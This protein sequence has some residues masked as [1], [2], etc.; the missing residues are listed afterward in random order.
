M[1]PD[2]PVPVRTFR[3]DSTVQSA[4]SGFEVDFLLN[5]ARY[6][7][8][9]SL[10]VDGVVEEWLSAFPNGKKQTWFKR[11]RGK[12]I[13][14]GRNLLGENKTIAGLTRP[15]SLFVST[16]A[17]NN[18][19]ALS[20]IYNWFVRQL[21]FVIG[22]R[23]VL[24][25]RTAEACMNE[26]D[27]L[28]IAELVSVADLGISDVKIQ[29]ENDESAREKTKRFFEALTSI[30]EIK[31][32]PPSSIDEPTPSF[33][34]LHRIGESIVPFDL[35]EESNGTIAY[36][37][38]LGPITRVLK[39]GGALFI[40][41]LDSGLHPLIV[42]H[43]LRLFKTTATN[44]R[45]AQLVFNT[46]DT[47]LLRKGLLRRDQVW[48]TEKDRNGQSHLYPLTDFKPRKEE[49]LGSGYLQGRFG[50]VPFINHET[51]TGDW[52]RDAEVR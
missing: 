8:G 34:L 35:D 25:R 39:N 31:G 49:N 9:F 52:D 5:G 29:V 7:Y 44:P 30:F 15:N 42:R 23:S 33:Q 36:L 38:L 20:P 47:S 12:P 22:D 16:A 19:E 18:H 28:A 3:G 46:H 6:Q 48:F 37:A 21:L 26:A 40:D 10:D 4:P 1:E 17:Q 27:R 13:S 51:V 2:Q 50:G 32:P 14:F 24:T 41:E 11:H 43:I 45:G